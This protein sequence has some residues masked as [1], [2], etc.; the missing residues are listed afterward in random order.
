MAGRHGQVFGI[1]P[2]AGAL[3]LARPR[4]GAHFCRAVGTAIPFRDGAFDLVL[5]SDVL[6][7]IGDDAR[8]ANEIRR[9]LRP[10]GS[11]IFS[12]PAHPWLFGPHDVALR[13]HRR[14]T[15]RA[16]RRVLEGAGLT[17]SWL[18]YWNTVLFPVVVAGRL[19][20]RFS[21]AGAKSDTRD[22]PPWLNAA[23]TGLLALE[24]RVLR[25]S[26][27]PCG[28]SLIGVALRPAERPQ[29]EIAR[30][31]ESACSGV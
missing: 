27:L 21:T 17:V 2:D 6:E 5:A 14:Y 1:E 28:V 24:A 15:R 13:H 31:A 26:R 29:D 10:G 20:R 22:A 8:A 19:V 25:V 18:S 4:G 3:A 30:S 7:H 23:L 9:V 16:I 12:V 11:L